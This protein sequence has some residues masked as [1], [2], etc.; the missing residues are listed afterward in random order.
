MKWHR[1]ARAAREREQFV[2]A[3]THELKTPLASIRLLAELLE[4]GDVEPER[5]R[6][7][8]ARTVAESDRLARLVD[9]VLRFARLQQG[10]ALPPRETVDLVE[11]A[12]AALRSVEPLAQLRGFT[13][14]LSAPQAP[15]LTLANADALIG[16][17]TELIDN[18]SKYGG[19][20]HALEI[21]VFR[22]PGKVG[23]A[24]L[25]RGP[26]VPAAER[27]RIFQPFHRVGDE[28]T[29]ER[30]GVGL[31]LALVRG[32]AESFGGTARYAPREGGGS[33]FVIELE[34]AP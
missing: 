2:A 23:V 12:R 6:D 17:V 32:V 27:E 28:L 14:E 22:V 29:R 3:V 8:G 30:P 26:G 5:V 18:A 21:E 4:R 13:L 9:S 16:V 34:C 15:V 19:A 20:P 25:D 31:G 11:V 1:E 33:R 10:G 7:F 24:V